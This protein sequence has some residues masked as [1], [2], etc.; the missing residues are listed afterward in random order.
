MGAGGQG[1]GPGP[2]GRGQRLRHG[3]PRRRP[4][5]L[6]PLPLH[7]PGTPRVQRR[8]S[9]PASI[10][11][12][13]AAAGD[14]Q[15][16]AGWVGGRVMCVWGAG[17]MVSLGWGGRVPAAAVGDDSA[18]RRAQLRLHGHLHRRMAGTPP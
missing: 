7:P 14:Y 4:P 1:G 9:D 17:L 11:D 13:G 3:L 15:L 16:G 5:P 12:N 8:Q 10:S 2:S 18:G 6:P